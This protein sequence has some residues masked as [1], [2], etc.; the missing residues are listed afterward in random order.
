[1]AE[2]LTVVVD[3]LVPTRVDAAISLKL[4][5]PKKVL[6]PITASAALPSA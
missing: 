6:P 4:I 5:G 1:M 3:V 2:L